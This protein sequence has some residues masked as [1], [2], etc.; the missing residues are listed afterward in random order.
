MS[1]AAHICARKVPSC[2]EIKF[3]AGIEAGWDKGCSAYSVERD[4]VLYQCRNN[5]ILG[6]NR[7]SQRGRWGR[8]KTCAQAH[9]EAER[10]QEQKKFNRLV[11]RAVD[12]RSR[13]TQR[14]PRTTRPLGPVDPNKWLSVKA[15]QEYGVSP[16]PM[17][18][19]DEY[20]PMGEGP[21]RGTARVRGTPTARTWG[22]LSSPRVMQPTNPSRRS[23]GARKRTPGRRSRSPVS[24]QRSRVA[25]SGGTRRLGRRRRRTRRRRTRHR[26]AHRSGSRRRR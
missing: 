8:K 20:A 18:I 7:C 22:S 26:R 10:A 12:Q 9:R 4:G 25:L 15:K 2:R 14:R 11:S 5:V 21:V 16:H 6:T 13:A 24:T 17:Q 3:S 19:G 1:R 23:E